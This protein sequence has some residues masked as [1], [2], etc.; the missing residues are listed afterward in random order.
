LLALI[1]NE[2]IYN[3]ESKLASPRNLAEASTEQ[4]TPTT[5]VAKTDAAA[6]VLPVVPILP[7]VLPVKVAIVGGLLING[8][9]VAGILVAVIFIIIAMMAVV[10]MM[11]LFVNTKIVLT[12]LLLGRVEY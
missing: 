12:P 11:S 2:G 5:D 9:G 6:A 3:V 7:V 4:V 8:N 1:K 10:S